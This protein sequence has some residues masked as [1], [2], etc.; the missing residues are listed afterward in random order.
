MIKRICVKSGLWD[1]REKT[2]YGLPKIMEGINYIN[3]F[4]IPAYCSGV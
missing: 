2:K 4:Q 3:I 1:A